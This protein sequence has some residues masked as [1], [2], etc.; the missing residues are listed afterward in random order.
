[1]HVGCCVNGKARLACSTRTKGQHCSQPS[2]LLSIY[3]EQIA[4]YLEVFHIPEDYQEKIMEAHRRLQSA[5]DD[6]CRETSRLEARLQ[7][8]R[9]LYE[10]GDISKDE[11][12]RKREAIHKE[13]RALTPPEDNSESLDRL[14]GFLGNVSK[15][16]GAADQE[17]RNRLA[18]C[19]FEELWIKDKE[20]VAVKPRPELEPFFRLNYEEFVTTNNEGATPK[21]FHPPCAIHRLFGRDPV[22]SGFTARCGA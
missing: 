14:A 22:P 8:V 5:Y 19:L 16:W 2:A 12:V 17:Q 15:A 4:A 1:M 7:R 6:V 13:L 9:D 18:R 21:G 10:L 11:Y 20:V 3:E